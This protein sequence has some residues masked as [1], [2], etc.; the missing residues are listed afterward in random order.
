MEDL[1]PL[2]AFAPG[3]DRLIAALGTA[4][5]TGGE[6]VATIESDTGLTVAILRR[7][8]SVAGRRR[9]TNVADAVALLD[10]REIEETVHGLPRAEFPWRVSQLEVRMHRIRVHAQAAARAADRIVNEVQPA[11]RDD[12]LTVA[13]LHDIGELL[14]ARALPAD[15]DAAKSA[16]M[17]PEAR[18]RDEQRT[19]GMDHA[20]LG[21]LLLRK[22]NLPA[23]IA[24][25]HTT[26]PRTRPT[27]RRTCG[28]RTWSRT[29]LRARAS[30]AAR[31][32][33]W[34]TCAGCRPTR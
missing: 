7:V 17:T 29:T 27:S 20:A 31:C 1:D 15:D 22:W 2:P 18:V 26:P 3:C 34:P 13:L 19:F 25:A 10:R 11:L 33:P 14:L 5:T 32:W 21:A 9:I 28:L 4:G 12:V 16:A 6:L 8:R 23:A 30:T 24:S